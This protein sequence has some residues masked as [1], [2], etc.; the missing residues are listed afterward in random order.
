MEFDWIRDGES[1]LEGRTGCLVTA[2]FVSCC[3]S[4]RVR[5][6]PLVWDG[7]MPKGANS[8]DSGVF[9]LI[10]FRLLYTNTPVLSRSQQ[11][12]GLP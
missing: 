6:S 2:F 9:L 11:L 7:E 5:R 3:I 4:H 12:W 1:A 10:E 8:I